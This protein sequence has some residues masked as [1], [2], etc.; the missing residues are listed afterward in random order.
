VSRKSRPLQQVAEKPR[1][2]ETSNKHTAGAEAR[3]LVIGLV[4][5][6]ESPAYR[7]NEI[8]RGL[9]ERFPE[10]GEAFDGVVVV[11]G[12]GFESEGQ[13]HAMGGGHGGGGGVEIDGVTAGGDGAIEDRLSERA[14][15]VESARD[16]THPE[17]L[18]FPSIGFNRRRDDAPGNESGG[19]VVG[20]RDEA[21]TALLV[22]TS[23]QAGCLLFKRAETEA[24]SAGLGDDEAAVFEQEFACLSERVVWSRCRDF[25]YRKWPGC[26]L[27]RV[28]T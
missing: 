20:V 2:A 9:L 19:L 10:I 1:I 23:G 26:G 8:F 6:D 5:K 17:A 4:A 18:Q 27:V 11:G 7:P 15:E 12:A 3:L 16:G 13:V 21:A 14:T 28:H 22:K 24:G 25:L